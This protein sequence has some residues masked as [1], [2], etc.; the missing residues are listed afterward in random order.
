[1]KLIDIDYISYGHLS[2]VVGV[3]DAGDLLIP[4]PTIEIL[5]DWKE[6]SYSQKVTA[7]SLTDFEAYL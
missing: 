2:I 7:K 1:M 6:K 3:K 5:F 4:C